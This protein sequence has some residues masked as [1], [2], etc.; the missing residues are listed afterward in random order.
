M[1]RVHGE[2]DGPSR[3]GPVFPAAEIDPLELSTKRNWDFPSDRV[4]KWEDPLVEDLFE[5]GRKTRFIALM[6]QVFNHCVGIEWKIN[7]GSSTAD[8]L[9][10]VVVR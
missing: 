2:I 9:K 5:A 7:L 6:A 8:A 4:V 1:K 10:G 3:K